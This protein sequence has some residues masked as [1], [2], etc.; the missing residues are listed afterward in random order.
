MHREAKTPSVQA[1]AW[2]RL[3]AA[4]PACPPNPNRVKTSGHSVSVIGYR[5]PKGVILG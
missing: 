1:A 5:L 2:V 4:C 3:P